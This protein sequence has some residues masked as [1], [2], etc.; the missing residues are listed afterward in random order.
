MRTV[1]GCLA[2]SLELTP[3][4]VDPESVNPESS[5]GGSTSVSHAIFGRAPRMHPQK[6][7]EDCSSRGIEEQRNR[8]SSLHLLSMAQPPGSGPG[9]PVVGRTICP[10]VCTGAGLAL[11]RQ[12]CGA[13]VALRCNDM[14]ATKVQR[15]LRIG[16]INGPRADPDSSDAR[17]LGCPRALA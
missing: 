11:H 14:D 13:I 4:G 2:E 3:G 5:A 9:L 1:L 17:A 8:S 10:S 6:P 12:M 16:V 7:L 15:R